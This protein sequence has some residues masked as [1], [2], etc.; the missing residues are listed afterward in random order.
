MGMFLRRGPYNPPTHIVTITRSGTTANMASVAI[1]GVTYRDAATLTLKEGT[2]ITVSLY[3]YGSGVS[4][5]A[6]IYFNGTQVASSPG[7][8]ETASYEFE[9]ASDTTI[10]LQNSGG[11]G[12][13]SWA[14]GTIYITTS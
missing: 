8:Y 2:K 7:N 9:L 3:A 5:Y 10:T 1:D 6:K 14:Y 13:T 4:S 11:T 12:N